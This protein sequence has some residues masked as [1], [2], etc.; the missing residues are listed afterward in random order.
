MS[1]DNV[2]PKLSSHQKPG[3]RHSVIEVEKGVNLWESILAMVFD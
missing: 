3:N 1:L 2:E